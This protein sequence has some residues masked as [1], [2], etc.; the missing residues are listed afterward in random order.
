MNLLEIR[1]LFKNVGRNIYFKNIIYVEYKVV[2][3]QFMAIISS[4]EVDVLVNLL[5]IQLP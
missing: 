2:K 5:T 4:F 3:Q 1:S